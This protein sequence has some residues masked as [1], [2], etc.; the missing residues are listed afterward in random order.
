MCA[1]AFLPGGSAASTDEDRKLRRRLEKSRTSLPTTSLAC[2]QQQRTPPRWTCVG[3]F[4]RTLLGNQG[5]GSAIELALAAPVLLLI[6]IGTIE[7]AHLY[8]VQSELTSAARQAA[9][10]LA[11]NAMTTDDTEAFVRARLSEVTQ[12][13]VTV[14]V[15]SADLQQNQADLTVHVSVP[16]RDVMLFG[17]DY[18]LPAGGDSSA[19][20]DSGSPTTTTET[21]TQTTTSAGP[22]LIA[23]ATMVKE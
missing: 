23:S 18:L 1:V 4:L 7:A 21:M 2:A 9:R 19:G 17:F 11:V 5:G 16:M 10:R 3:R 13:V 20:K 6:L 22:T 12:A 8:L 14:S 15:A